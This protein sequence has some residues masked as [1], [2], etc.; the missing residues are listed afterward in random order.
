MS[1]NHDATVER[2][3]DP[4]CGMNVRLDAAIADGLAA[5]HDGHTYYFCRAG[6]LEAFAADPSRFITAHAHAADAAP[7][8]APVIDDGMRRWYE[9]CACCLSDAYPEVKAALDAERTADQPAV[10]P[11]ICEVAEAA[12]AST[13]ADR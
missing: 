11:G 13:A 2:Q 5:E 7:A 10:A 3:R 6:C 1:T 4:V 9:S 12:E 8:S